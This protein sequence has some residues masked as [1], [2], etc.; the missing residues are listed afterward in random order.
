MALQIAPL[1]VFERRILILL[2]LFVAGIILVHLIATIWHGGDYINWLL[3]WSLLAM[4][5]GLG[6]AICARHNAGHD[7]IFLTSVTRYP[8]Y[9]GK[10][11]YNIIQKAGY[12]HLIYIDKNKL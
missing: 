1:I 2:Y 9:S 10:Q 8:C 7:W 3:R 5:A 12:N 11:V 4:I 6:A